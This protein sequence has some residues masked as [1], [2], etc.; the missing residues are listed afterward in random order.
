MTQDFVFETED[1]FAEHCYVFFEHF[2]LGGE[3]PGST[4][5]AI[6]VLLLA[7]PALVGG[8]AV[9]FEVCLTRG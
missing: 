4:F 7:L 9:L 2:V 8:D 5:E 1:F 6:D 3:F